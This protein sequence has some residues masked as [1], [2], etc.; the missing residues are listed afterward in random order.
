MFSCPI[1]RSYTV[2]IA[3]LYAEATQSL[4]LSCTQKLHSLYC[5]PV[6]RSYT[7][8][9]AVP[10]IPLLPDYQWTKLHS[11]KSNQLVAQFILSIFIF[12][13]L[14]MFRATV[15]RNNSLYATLVPFH[16]AYQTV[17]HTEQVQMTHKHNFFNIKYQKI[18][19]GWVKT[20]HFLLW[21]KVSQGRRHVSA[22][23]YKAIIRWK[24]KR[25]ITMLHIAYI[26]SML[27]LREGG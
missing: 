11:F 23:Y 13:N 10:Y 16:P 3:V 14:Y 20:Q 1:R 18:S 21:C 7:V 4:L 15:K 27:W 19:G 25:K 26:H 9:I 22:L 17:I 24:L 8:S 6:R 12:I 5:C 2:S